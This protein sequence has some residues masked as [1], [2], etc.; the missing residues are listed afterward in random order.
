MS[1]PISVQTQVGLLIQSSSRV[2]LS[3]ITH[4]WTDGSM[5]TDYC[6]AIL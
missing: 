5:G 3:E 6:W 4:K 2:G 1:R